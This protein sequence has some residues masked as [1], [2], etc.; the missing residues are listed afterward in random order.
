MDAGVSACGDVQSCL[1][2]C[3]KYLIGFFPFS[4]GFGELGT[5]RPPFFSKGQ[6]HIFQFI[7]LTQCLSLEMGITELK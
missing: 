3:P 2:Q 7:P 6:F 5:S 1:A 4:F